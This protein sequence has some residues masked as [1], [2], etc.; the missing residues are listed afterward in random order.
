MLA[1]P[2]EDSFVDLRQ[3]L[4]R[5]VFCDANGTAYKSSDSSS[6]RVVG[7][8]V[9]RE[10]GKKGTV[11][12]FRANEVFLH[13]PLCGAVNN[14]DYKYAFLAKRVPRRQYART[15]CA[16]QVRT[17]VP[18]G[19][20]V[21]SMLKAPSPN[22]A[23]DDGMRALFYPAYPLDYRDALLWLDDGWAS[24]ALSRRFILVRA[25]G[26]VLVYDEMSHVGHVCDGRFVSSVEENYT[27]KVL[28][29]FKGALQ[30]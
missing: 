30:L 10:P 17:S 21:L 22:P 5:G 11:R 23:T 27:M 18:R 25:E 24:V 20:E 13:W 4:H 26:K 12:D 28:K 9:P 2:E 7:V 15:F 19:F 1:V 14:I 8:S 6:S 16:E 29:A 3:W